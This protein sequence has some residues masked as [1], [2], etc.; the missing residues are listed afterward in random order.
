M[1]LD[2]PYGGEF[3][4]SPSPLPGRGG[5]KRTTWEQIKDGVKDAWNRATGD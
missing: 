4:A 2:P 5:E 3:L 1:K